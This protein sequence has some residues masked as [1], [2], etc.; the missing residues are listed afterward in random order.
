MD[1]L[2]EMEEIVDTD[3]GVRDNVTAGTGTSV[4]IGVGEG[5]LGGKEIVDGVGVIDSDGEDGTDVADS[6]LNSVIG[7]SR[8]IASS[9]VYGDP[10]GRRNDV[11]NDVSA[12]SG[13]ASD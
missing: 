9:S 2:I 5:T 10:L 1:E 3:D 4:E 6:V 11:S 8:L 12:P 13:S 7:V